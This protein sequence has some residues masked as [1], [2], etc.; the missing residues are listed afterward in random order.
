[1]PRP[2]M[3]RP[4]TKPARASRKGMSLLEVV[5]ASLL[6]AL[7][8]TTVVG[9]MTAVVQQDLRQRAKI[10]AL[11]VGNRLMLTYLD[12]AESIKEMEGKHVMQGGKPY[13]FA[14]RETPVSINLPSG[15][16][17]IAAGDGPAKDTFRQ[18]VLL[19]VNVYQALGN[20][21]QGYQPG[22]LL[23]TISRPYHPLAIITRGNQDAMMR[24]MT[25]E[26]AIRLFSSLTGG[27]VGNT[28]PAGGKPSGA[29][30]GG[31]VVGSEFAGSR[32]R[33]QGTGG[34]FGSNDQ[35]KSN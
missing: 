10:D 34:K 26:N 28:K 16:L 35:R 19:T 8:V 20:D 11:E 9:G 12:D 27:A 32:D 15:G 21:Q 1:M 29:G 23:C 17:L 22:E 13:V 31:A 30:R 33:G 5:L 3:Q 6:V 14:F 25:P 18:S 7:V 24:N 2:T 4:R